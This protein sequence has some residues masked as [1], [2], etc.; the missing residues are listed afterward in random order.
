MTKRRASNEKLDEIL[1]R[2]YTIEIEYGE[3]PEEGVA[4]Y[5][6]E[7]P[8]CITAGATPEE[9]LARIGGAMRDWAAARLARRQRGA[10]PPK[11]YGGA[12]LPPPPP[13]PSPRAGER[14]G[15]HGGRPEP[16]G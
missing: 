2:P 6:A 3:T 11:E 14:G 15:K 10:E 16:K 13:R 4:A 12:G 7:W 5:V 1:R 8:G 9:G